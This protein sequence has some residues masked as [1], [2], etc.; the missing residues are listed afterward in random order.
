MIV[1][2]EV[3]HR[4]Q[5]D[6]KGAE[7][8]TG[9]S[10]FIEK[11]KFVSIVGPNGSGKSTLLKLVKGIEI[12]DE[13]SIEVN[14]IS[15]VDPRFKE[16]S[17]REIGYILENPKM[18]I[19]SPVVQEDILFSLENLRFEKEEAEDRLLKISKKLEIEKLLKRSVDS[20]SDGEIQ[21]VA[22][23]GILVLDAEILLSDESTAWLDPTSSLEI[24]KFFKQLCAE[25][26]TIL[27]VTHDPLEMVLSDLVIVL[28]NKK[29]AAFGTPEEVFADSLNLYDA[30]IS[31]PIS[32]MISKYLIDFGVD[33][34]KPFLVPEEFEKIA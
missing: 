2:K 27:H 25:G 6:R 11:G 8:L 19:V 16:F 34:K 14:G 30:G 13:G 3:T 17:Q 33:L 7:T 26:K 20:L 10:F 9:L 22:L 29:I 24:I 5:K 1:F 15:T 21:R 23:A 18:Q 28:S 32:S 4:Y 12:P 31:V